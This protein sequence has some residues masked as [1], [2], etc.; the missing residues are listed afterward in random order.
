MYRSITG[1]L[2]AIFLI[3]SLIGPQQI[4]RQAGF[5]DEFKLYMPLVF[6]TTIKQVVPTRTPRPTQTRTPTRTRTPF[7]SA[8]PLPTSTQTPTVT[9][10]PTNTNTPTPTFTPTL[11]PVPSITIIFPTLTPTQ[12][13]TKTPT[14]TTSPTPSTTPGIIEATRPTSWILVILVCL[15]WIILGVGLF[16]FF[17]RQEMS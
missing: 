4:Q 11:I 14:L 15:L 10:T 2:S 16:F 5:Q 6:R 13:P 1:Y 8:T 9:I 17:R 3:L 7:R 12:T